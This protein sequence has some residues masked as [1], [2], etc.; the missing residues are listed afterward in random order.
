MV[1]NYRTCWKCEAENEYPTL[2]DAL[3]GVYP[4]S[5]CGIEMEFQD[6]EKRQIIGEFMDRIDKIEDFVGRMAIAGNYMGWE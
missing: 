5:S 3:V 2:T 4:C 6:F 1:A